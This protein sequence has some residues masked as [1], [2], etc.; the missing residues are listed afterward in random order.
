MIMARGDT[1]EVSDLPPS[2]RGDDSQT[3][4]LR[5]LLEMDFDSLKEA[6]DWYEKAYIE[7]KLAQHEGNV[8]KTADSLGVERSNLYRKMKSLGIDAVKV[9]AE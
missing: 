7:G 2:I 3:D 6:R 5:T 9:R 1:I 8:S 4:R